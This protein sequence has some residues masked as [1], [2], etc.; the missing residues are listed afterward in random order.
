V[1]L[2]GTIDRKEQ[3]RRC[4]LT[5]LVLLGSPVP[6]LVVSYGPIPFQP[7]ERVIVAGSLDAG[8][9]SLLLGDYAGP[10]EPLVRGGMPLRLEE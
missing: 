1:L 6:V 2:V 4:H 7:G 9:P 3:L 5:R 8:D 10:R